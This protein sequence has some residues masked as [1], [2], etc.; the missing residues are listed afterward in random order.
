MT[1]YDR[2]R[3]FILRLGVVSG[4][5]GFLGRALAMGT[6][7]AAPGF[8]RVRGDVR[9]NDRQAAEGGTV[10]RG[11]TVVTGTGAEAVYVIGDTAVLQRGSTT[12]QFASDAAKGFMRV[13]TGRILSVFGPG[14]KRLVVPTATIGIRGTACYIEDEGT[15]TYFCLC[16]GMAEVVPSAAP[17]EREILHTEHHDHPI[18]IHSDPGMPKSMV[19]ATVMNHTD[20]ELM[21]L[22]SLVG[23]VPPFVGRSLGGAYGR[24]PSE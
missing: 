19:P 24:A 8:Q 4:L 3:R 7:P 12:V 20:A 17:Q 22:E 21:L 5:A 15:R 9:V 16:Y 11:D 14:D 13:V 23:R 18:Y 10:A 1:S 2:P 6:H